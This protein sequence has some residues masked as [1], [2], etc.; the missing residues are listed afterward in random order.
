MSDKFSPDNP[1]KEEDKQ[2]KKAAHG[3]G[4]SIEQYFS[5]AGIHPFDQL[6]WDKRSAK[7]ASDSGEAI[8]E[9]EDIPISCTITLRMT[10]HDIAPV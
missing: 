5:T 1:F 2:I 8:F 10:G 7:I 9:Q 3:K 4:L 6:E